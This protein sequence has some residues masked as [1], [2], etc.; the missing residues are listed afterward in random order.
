MLHP[1]GFRFLASLTLSSWNSFIERPV[2]PSPDASWPPSFSLKGVSSYQSH[3]LTDLAL[4]S[5]ERALCLQN[6]FPISGLARLERVKL[7]LSRSSWRDLASTQ[8]L[9]LLPFTREALFGCPL[10]PT[11]NQFSFSMELT[12]FTPCSRSDPLLSR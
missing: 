2:A 4:S 7:G 9:M 12:F 3:S 1:N 11:R 5:Y 6:S 8:S 10:S